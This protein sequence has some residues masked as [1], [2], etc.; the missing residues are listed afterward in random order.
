MSGLQLG[1]TPW[2]FDT[3]TGPALTEQAV[4]LEQLGY[5]SIWLPENHFNEQALPDPLMLL[6]SVA[7]GT[8]RLKLGTTSYLLPIRDPILAAEQ[9]AVVDVLS[10]G[11]VVL[12]V[13]RGLSAPMFRAFAVDPKTKRTRFEASLAVMRDA[14]A[15]KPVGP[16]GNTVEVHPQPVQK[17]HPPIWA[18]AIGPKALAQA[19]RLGLAYLASPMETVVQLEHNYRAHRDAARR[20]E[21]A[22]AGALEVP[23]MRTLY[24]SESRQQTERIR[25]RVLAAGRATGR[26]DEASSVDDFAIVGDSHLARDKLAEY[27]DRLGVTKLIVTR[28]RVPG[29]DDS[30]FKRSLEC[31]AA[32]VN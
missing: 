4:F 21:S 11:R 26:I 7:A 16:E 5:Q 18:A 12:G 13:G 32:L 19:G 14:W 9:V 27:R 15:G 17:P 6:A 29:I 20:A 25:E 8:R 28:L 22:G 31:A 24:I 3:L 23:V 10:G 30:D 1:A 2:R